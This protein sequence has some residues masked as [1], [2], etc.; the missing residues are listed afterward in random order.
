[1]RIHVVLSSCGDDGSFQLQF[2]IPA[3]PT[4]EVSWNKPR[5]TR[6]AQKQ[7]VPP[8]SCDALHDESVAVGFEHASHRVNMVSSI[9]CVDVNTF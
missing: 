3:A 7:S 4:E 2:D 5:S 1:M 8:Y 9:T 6:V